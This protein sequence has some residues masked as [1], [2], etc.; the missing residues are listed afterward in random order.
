MILKLHRKKFKK[1]S[2]SLKVIA[3]WKWS[4]LDWS[5]AFRTLLPNIWPNKSF[6]RYG[7]RNMP[8]ILTIMSNILA[9]FQPK[10]K[11]QFWENV[12]KVYSGPFLALFSHIWANRSFAEKSGCHFSCILDQL[13]P[14]Y[15]KIII[16]QLV[17]PYERRP[18]GWGSNIYTF[19]LRYKYGLV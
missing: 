17:H 6:P 15:Q 18:F 11:T 13:N 9:C 16:S 1:L 8:Y 12:E 2:N 3:F 14:K 7:W 10:V 4:N 5:G 19:I